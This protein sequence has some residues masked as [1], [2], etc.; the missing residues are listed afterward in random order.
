MCTSLRSTMD[1]RACPQGPRRSVRPQSNAETVWQK[2]LPARTPGVAD[3]ARLVR[4]ARARRTRPRPGKRRRNQPHAVNPQPGQRAAT[5]RRR[6]RRRSPW[7]GVHRPARLQWTAFQPSPRRE[8]GASM[9]RETAV[10][11][12]AGKQA[13]R[14]RRQRRPTTRAS[15]GQAMSDAHATSG[16]RARQ[17]ARCLAPRLCPP[18]PASQ[19]PAASEGERQRS[20]PATRGQRTGSARATARRRTPGPSCHTR[21]VRRRRPTS[22]WQRAR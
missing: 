4:P 20:H 21:G 22:H 11:Q 13:R 16:R 1:K 12:P 5:G 9:T 15:L 10:P 14:P 3:Q 19:K 2:L 8:M 18:L 7:G 17:A 6:A